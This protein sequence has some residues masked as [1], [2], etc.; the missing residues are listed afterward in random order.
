VL[1]EEDLRT[2][3]G[4]NRVL[5]VCTDGQHRPQLA[6]DL[7]G[8]RRESAGAAEHQLAAAHLAHDG[9]VHMAQ[10]RPVVHQEQVRDAG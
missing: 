2:D 4:G 3:G 10:D 6:L 7:D 1:T 9:I 8:Q 5:L